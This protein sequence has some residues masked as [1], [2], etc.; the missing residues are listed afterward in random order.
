MPCLATMCKNCL[1]YSI[2]RSIVTSIVSK[3]VEDVQNKI[4][5]LET[6]METL[7]KSN[8][9]FIQNT[10]TAIESLENEKN[11]KSLIVANIPISRNEN[12]PKIIVTLASRVNCIIKE[13]DVDAVFRIKSVKPANP[14]LIM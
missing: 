4:E 8:A 3:D 12:L 11:E 5:E 1:Q 13:S 2:P 14:S 10:E 7:Q 9:T 6:A